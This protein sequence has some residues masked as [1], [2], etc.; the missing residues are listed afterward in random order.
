MRRRVHKHNLKLS[1]NRLWA[2][3]A[4]IR[5]VVNVFKRKRRAKST[6]TQTVLTKLNA[7]QE[8]LFK[9]LELQKGMR[10]FLG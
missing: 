5:E 1:L 8:K 10:D 9:I 2:E 6:P 4:E 3:L 7:P